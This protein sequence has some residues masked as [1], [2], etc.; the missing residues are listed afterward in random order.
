MVQKKQQ[1]NVINKIILGKCLDAIKQVPDGIVSLVCCSPPYLLGID[2]KSHDD[3]GPWK[4]YIDW[5][6]AIWK[7]CKRT[8][9]TGGRLAINMATITNREDPENE[10]I[11]VIGHYLCQ[12]M[13]SIGMLPMAEIVWYKQDAAGKKTAWGSWASCSSPIIRSTHEYVYVFAKDTY[14]LDGDSEL[15]DMTPEEF[16]NWTFS[17]W[18]IPPETRKMGGHPCPFPE[19]LVCRLVKLYSYREDVVLDP[20][21][22]SGTTPYISDQLGRKYIGIDVD[23]QYVDYARDRIANNDDMF[24]DGGEY[25]PRSKRLKQSKKD[26]NDTDLEDIFEEID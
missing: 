17:T 25:V 13:K 4:A 3:T 20:F 19:E 14:R 5:L 21:C 22:G 2:Y 6:T 26:N 16:Q 15:S 8:L 18:F 9:R 10:Y 23:S 12:Q 1:E 11:R 7:E 24:S